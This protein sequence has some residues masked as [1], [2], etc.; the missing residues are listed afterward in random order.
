M[1][2]VKKL[3]ILTIAAGGALVSACAARSSP[4]SAPAGAQA[5]ASILIGSTPAAGSTVEAPVDELKLR[6]DPPARLEELTV[7]G[8]NGIMPMMV[9]A[10]GK[11]S[12]YSLPL[13]GL[14]AGSYTVDW[15]ASTGGSGHRGSFTF[16]VR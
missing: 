3:T 5:P 13:S 9:D 14:E 1:V 16:T 15:R 4:A 7:T 2:A 11:V 8:P 10:V 12:D 6:F